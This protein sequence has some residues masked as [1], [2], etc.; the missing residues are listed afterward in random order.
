MTTTASLE[1]ASAFWF[2]DAAAAQRRYVGRASMDDAELSREFRRMCLIATRID[3]DC[4]SVIEFE[5]QLIRLVELARQMSRDAAVR[6]FIEI[7]RGVLEAP[8]ESVPFCMHALR[9][10]EILDEVKRFVGEPPDPRW[11]NYASHVSD[12]YEDHWQDRDLWSYFREPT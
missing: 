9:F 1:L 10:P 8:N 3:R 5:P 11:M 7:V 12:A 4:Q 6:C 2:P